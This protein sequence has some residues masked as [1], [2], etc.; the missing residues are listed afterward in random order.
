MPSASRSITIR[1]SPE[2]V[3][4]FVADGT[5]ATQWRPG[6]TDIRLV[7]GSGMGA[8]YAQG[9]TG[10]GGRRVDADYE[11]TAWDPPRRMAFAATAGPVRPTGEYRLAADPGGTSLTFSLDAKVG[12]LKGLL[13][14]RAVQSSMD[15]EMAALDRLKQV[16]EST[17]SGV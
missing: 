13:M 17:A 12:G 3:F 2:D 11:V 1:R 6:V 7:S 15:A 4:A 14:G 8:R 9:V 5:T 10:P 16:L